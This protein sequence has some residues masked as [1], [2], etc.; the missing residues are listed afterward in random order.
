M[1]FILN[2]CIYSLGNKHLYLYEILSLKQ[3][4][5]RI[6]MG[7]FQECGMRIQCFCDALPTELNIKTKQRK[8]EKK[9]KKEKK[10]FI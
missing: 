8:K 2:V 4:N 5:K 3:N 10:M 6:A 9:K 1:H 7:I